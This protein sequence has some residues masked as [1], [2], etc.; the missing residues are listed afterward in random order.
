[1]VGLRDDCPGGPGLARQRGP[2]R[3]R[4]SSSASVAAAATLGVR[5][6]R[7][8]YAFTGDLP[9]SQ[10]RRSTLKLAKQPRLRHAPLSLHRSSRH[11]VHRHVLSAARERAAKRRLHQGVRSD[12]VRRNLR[13]GQ[14]PERRGDLD[15]HLFFVPA[16]TPPEIIAKL[17]A[18]TN[19]ALAHP[20][21]KPRFDDLGA[22]P[23]G[24]TPGQLAA[25]LNSEIDKWGPIIRATG[26]FAD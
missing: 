13:P 23:R 4:N 11:D 6:V 12:V 2:P 17:N 15:V 8:V 26:T 7:L 5:S 10:I 24:T 19:A 25:F 16:K 21:V 14:A 3:R 18:D 9:R 20:S 22:T 1:M